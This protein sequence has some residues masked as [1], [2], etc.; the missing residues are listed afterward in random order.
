VNTSGI[1]YPARAVT[2]APGT[3]WANS[4]NRVMYQLVVSWLNSCARCIQ[5]DHAIA[6]WW[7]IPFH[8]NCNCRQQPIAP[9]A[10]A[11]P[12][13][14]FRER[15]QELPPERR[16]HVMG[17]ANYRL[18]E[19]GL[20][21]WT[22]VVTR[23][24]I[25][26][27]HEVAQRAGLDEKALAKAGVDPRS[28]RQAVARVQTPARAAQVDANRAIVERLKQLGL[29]DEQIKQGV[30][31]RIAARVAITGKPGP[32]GRGSL[33]P[34]AP[35]PVSPRPAPPSRPASAP[36]PIAPAARAPTLPPASRPT[37]ASRPAP[38]LEIE[39][40]AEYLRLDLPAAKKRT[41]PDESPA[42]V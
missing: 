19:Q 30:A 8:P 18:V 17:V 27:L 9:G 2:G 6:P 20:V 10:T 11:D 21:K 4:G 37:L 26:P 1:V 35:A 33:P 28:A 25:R 39:Q 22:D 38:V 13:V 23:S 16:R 32:G 42:G 41:S 40:I 34:M 24:R 15:L 5:Y 31:S 29:S 3:A 7:P 36:T 12:F 14:D